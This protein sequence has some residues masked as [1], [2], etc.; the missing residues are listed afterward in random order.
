MNVISRYINIVALLNKYLTKSRKTQLYSVFFLGFVTIFF[1]IFSLALIVPLLE[2]TAVEYGIIQSKDATTLAKLGSFTTIF[3]TIGLVP[4]FLLI[5]FSYLLRIFYLWLRG[6]VA[7]EIEAAI[8]NR[9]TTNVLNLKF[10]SFQ[11][12]FADW[13]LQ[14]LTTR[15]R[16]LSVFLYFPLIDLMTNLLFILM[17]AFVLMLYSN[18][19][20][21]T[22]AV[23]I[24]MVYILLTLFSNKL[25]NM[26]GQKLN[27]NAEKLLTLCKSVLG[28][29]ADTKFLLNREH[30]L[31]QDRETRFDLAK[32]QTKT[33]FF[34][35][36]PKLTIELILIMLAVFGFFVVAKNYSSEV[37]LSTLPTIILFVVAAQKSI[38]ILQRLFVCWTTL[39]SECASLEELTSLV[40]SSETDSERSLEY[41]AKRLVEVR[42]LSFSYEAKKP[43]L[44]NLSFQIREKERIAIIGRSG[45]GKSTLMRCI[46]GL[47]NDYEGSIEFGEQFRGKK[48]PDFVSYV[49]QENTFFEGSMS[50]NITGFDTDVDRDVLSRAMLISGLRHSNNQLEFGLD[51]RISPGNVLLSGG[52]KQRLALARAIYKQPKILVLDEFT[53]SLDSGIKNQIME[54]IFADSREYTIVFTTHDLSQLKYAT[55]YAELRGGKLHWRK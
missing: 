34:S 41:G 51:T 6:K 54:S 29:V 11:G 48:Y 9:L 22:T 30:L 43:I 42:N 21:M 2:L 37:M 35:N 32:M 18:P 47:M 24:G 40:R 50:Q 45:S 28:N 17:L 38:P 49:G 13:V 39:R 15:A 33:Q 20:V 12:D 23:L 36:L 3:G 10:D 19:Y 16:R 26:A 1:E 4:F 55:R 7:Y 53:N 25:F 44:R 52:Q 14:S 31:Q 27:A 46:C 8:G 5:V